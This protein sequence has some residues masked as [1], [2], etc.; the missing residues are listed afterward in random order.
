MTSTTALASKVLVQVKECDLCHQ[1]IRVV[2]DPVKGRAVAF[3][4]PSGEDH[5]CWDLP[6]DAQVLVIEDE[7]CNCGH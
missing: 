1:L 5:E 7:D 6:S 4:E 3:D 2:S